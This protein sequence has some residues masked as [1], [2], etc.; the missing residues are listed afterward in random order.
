M[1]SDSEEVDYDERFERVILHAYSRC[2]D[3]FHK[4]LNEGRSLEE[5]RSVMQQAGFSWRML[6]G[7][8]I[9]VYPQDYRAVVSATARLEL[10]PHH[11]IMSEPFE[12]LVREALGHLP[13][14][15]RVDLR[16]AATVAYLNEIGDICCTERTFLSIPRMLRAS[17]S[18]AQSTTELRGSRMCNPRRKMQKAS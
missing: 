7:A 13:S 18:V 3:V 4:A 17:N 16:S 1:G 8:K 6:S 5:I 9:F 12:P 10:R 14:R 11:V 15:R 2:P